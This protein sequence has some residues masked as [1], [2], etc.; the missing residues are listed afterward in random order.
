MLR[1]EGYRAISLRHEST[2]DDFIDSC[3]II[4]LVLFLATK[5]TLGP[6]AN[7]PNM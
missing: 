3:G 2:G 1:N 6:L 4:F 7:D 5:E